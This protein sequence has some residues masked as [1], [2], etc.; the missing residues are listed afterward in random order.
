VEEESVYFVHGTTTL[1]WG[2]STAIDGTRGHGEL[3]IGFYVFADTNWG[4]QAACQW[5]RRK[6]LNDGGTPVLVLV[7]MAQNAFVSL[8]HAEITDE[9]LDAIYRVYSELGVIGRDVVVGPVG[10]NG[11]DGRR[12][13]DKRL[14]RQCK[15]EQSGIAALSIDRVIPCP[16]V[17]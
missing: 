14:P 1:L 9:A 6:M 17:G 10:R 11:L 8:S 16:E 12:I 2:G 15:F 3:G 5:A 13:P 7:R 4:R